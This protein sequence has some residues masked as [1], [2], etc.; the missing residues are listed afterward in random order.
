MQNPIL[1]I[2]RDPDYGWLSAYEAGRVHEGQPPSRWRPLGTN[3]AYWCPPRGRRPRGF[4]IRDLDR[5]DVDAPEVAE[6]WTGPRFAV[7]LLTLDD[8]TAGE[9]I[10]AARR[11]LGDTPTLNRVYFDAATGLTGEEALNAWRCCL[12]AGDMMAHFAIGYTLYEL[13]RYHEAYGHLRHY[14]AIAPHTSWNWCWLGKGAAAIGEME[15]ARR[16]FEKAIELTNGGGDETD[17]PELLA[18]LT[19]HLDRANPAGRPTDG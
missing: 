3:F 7:P 11:F 10:V 13:E 18:G 17:A 12:E 19:C 2:N 8:A 6:I 9:I 14:A 1:L 15:E 16:A 4:R 5:L